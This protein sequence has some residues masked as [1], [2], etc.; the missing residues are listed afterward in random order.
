MGMFIWLG[1]STVV[2]MLGNLAENDAII[3]LGGVML[4]MLALIP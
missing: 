4:L 1:L 3:G 2:V